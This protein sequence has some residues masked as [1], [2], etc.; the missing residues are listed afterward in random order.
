MSGDPD[1][2]Q[3]ANVE[4]EI[5]GFDMP[6]DVQFGH[7]WGLDG[8]VSYTR[9]KRVDIDDNLYRISPPN[10]RARL[11]YRPAR[12]SLMLENILYA[13]QEHVS[14]TNEEQETAGYSLFNP[15]PTSP[16]I[17]PQPG[18]FNASGSNGG[19]L[20]SYPNPMGAPATTVPAVPRNNLRPAPTMQPRPT[21]QPTP[22]P[23]V[24]PTQMAPTLP[25]TPGPSAVPPVPGGV[26][27]FPPNQSAYRPATI[28][29]GSRLRNFLT[30]P[31]FQKKGGGVQQASWPNGQ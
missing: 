26:Q 28:K 14:E 1:P 25:A 6:W 13:H 4:A 3:F 11:T 20:P 15:P 9:G 7:S 23:P 21:I 16:S 5:Y 24:P 19:S 27:T 17:A 29:S 18:S 30:R 31:V 8:T 10:A 22:A 2:L 12:W